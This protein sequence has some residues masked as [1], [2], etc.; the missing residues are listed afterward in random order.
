MSMKLWLIYQHENNR[1]DT[2]DSAVVAAETEADAQ[3]TNPG[4]YACAAEGGLWA[5][6]FYPEPRQDDAWANWDKV[7]VQLLGDALE[8]TPPRVICASYNAG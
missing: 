4:E 6:S 1:Y 5:F 8:G 3:R 7:K 2:Y